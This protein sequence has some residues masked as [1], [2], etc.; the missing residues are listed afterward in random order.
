MAE[1]SRRSRTP[2]V[3]VVVVLVLAGALVGVDRGVHAYAEHRATNE[4]QTSL[5]TTGPPTVDIQGFPFLNQVATNRFPR[6]DVTASG[7]SGQGQG[8]Q[9]GIQIQTLQ[10]QLY[11]VSTANGYRKVTAGRL[12][13]H[14]TVGYSVLDG[15]TTSP[16]SFAGNESAGP[17]RIKTTVAAPISGQQLNLTLTGAPTVDE[18]NQQIVIV[19]PAIQIAG[20]NL[21][22]SVVDALAAQFLKPIPVGA[23]PLGVR[24]VGVQA[25]SA[26]VV[27]EVAGNDVVVS[28]G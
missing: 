16:I 1:R 3:V 12:E 4:L 25:T 10:A 23:L 15:Y 18:A 19:D 6:I 13:G 27:A 24:L 21:S 5:A 2:L 14:A 7:V 11:D 20:I 8:G 17:G 9:P 28:D 26:G 22:Q